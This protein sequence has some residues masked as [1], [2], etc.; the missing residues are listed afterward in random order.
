[1]GKR[2]AVRPGPGAF[3]PA[4]RLVRTITGGQFPAWMLT[5]GVRPTCLVCLVQRPGVKIFMTQ[6]ALAELGFLLDVVVPGI[7]FVVFVHCFSVPGVY[8]PL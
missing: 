6:P 5:V 2:P 3:F 4:P 7:S 1:M 8:R